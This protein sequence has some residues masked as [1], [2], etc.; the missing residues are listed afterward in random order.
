VSAYNNN[1]NNNY[2]TTHEKI[3]RTQVYTGIKSET[4]GARRIWTRCQW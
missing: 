4:R 3:A 1:S 2:D